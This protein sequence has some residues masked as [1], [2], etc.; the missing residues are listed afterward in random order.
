MRKKIILGVLLSSIFSAG[1]FSTVIEVKQKKLKTSPIS[2]QFLSTE[3]GGSLHATDAYKD[4]VG[5]Y[6]VGI[7][8]SKMNRAVFSQ[9]AIESKESGKSLST[10]LKE[11]SKD[12]NINIIELSTVSE[13]NIGDDCDDGNSETVHDYIVDSKG[14]CQGIIKRTEPKCFGDEIGSNFLVGDDEVMFLVVD[15]NTI[16]NNLERAETLC[17]SNVSNMAYLFVGNSSFNQDISGWDTSNVS[18]MQG[19]F[20]KA[21]S[22][23]QDIGSWNV[24]NVIDMTFMFYNATSFN[25][26][27]TGWCTASLFDGTNEPYGFAPNL[28]E[29]KKP[30]WGTCP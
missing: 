14:T 10:V 2:G 6:V 3:N 18:N 27:L 9:D 24:S 15:N 8:N 12:S 4:G 1:L 17:V 7:D 13:G 21:N 28:A 25:Q 22:F 11:K 16:R 30:V 5:M 29:S 23:N 20:N 26:D 19:M